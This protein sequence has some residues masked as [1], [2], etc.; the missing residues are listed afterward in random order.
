MPLVLDG[1]N[2]ISSNGTNFNIRPTDTGVVLN[3]LAT[4]PLQPSFKVHCSGSPSVANSGLIPWNVATYNNG[5]HYT[6]S[7]TASASR[8]TAPVR[9]TYVFGGMV[10]MDI[11]TTYI[12]LNV[13]LNGVNNNNNGELPGLT[14]TF[15]GTGFCAAPFVYARFL[16]AGDFIQFWCNNPGISPFVI[17]PQSFMYGYLVG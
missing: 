14:S 10:R 1:S 11:N 5:N 4:N 9:G 12:H 17:N 13:I 3:G 8:F 2:G 7:S 6:V 15:N 16:E